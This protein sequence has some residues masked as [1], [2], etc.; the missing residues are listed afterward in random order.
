MCNC[1]CNCQS[2][3]TMADLCGQISRLQNNYDYVVKA[4]QSWKRDYSNLQEE[5]KRVTK[6]MRT[7]QSLVRNLISFKEEENVSKTSSI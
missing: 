2:K 4:N 5:L 3:T 7:A 6:K 1:Q